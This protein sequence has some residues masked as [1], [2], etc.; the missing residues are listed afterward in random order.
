[1]K[2]HKENRPWGNFERFSHNEK[3]TVK[4]LQ[5]NPNEA[6]SLQF[7]QHRDEFWRVI[8]GEGIVV[9]G[10]EVVKCKKGD[11]FYVPSETNYQ[12]RTGNSALTILEISFGNFDENDIVRLEDRYNRSV[13]KVKQQV[14]AQMRIE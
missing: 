10:D 12:I 3:T 14:P 11:E 9:I 13:E 8:E 6:Q 1:M 7:H 4:I 2:T 5:I